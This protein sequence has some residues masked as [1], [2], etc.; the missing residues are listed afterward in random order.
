M[1]SRVCA[2]GTDF[3]ATGFKSRFGLIG[4]RVV[5]GGPGGFACDVD[6][7]LGALSSSNIHS[8]G[9]ALVVGLPNSLVTIGLVCLNSGAGLVGVLTEILG[10]PGGV[11]TGST[12]L[13]PK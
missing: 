3:S 2:S 8:T 12:A 6:R 1:I 9:D 4:D 5:V 7:S 11:T 10:I 13:E